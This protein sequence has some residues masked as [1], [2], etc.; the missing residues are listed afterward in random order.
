MSDIDGGGWQLVRHVPAGTVWH[1]ATD[2]LT[3]TDS[4]GTPCGPTCRHEW[5]VRF[6]NI[7]FNQFL[8]I[9]GDRKKWLIANKDQ[10]IGS[11]YSNQPRLVNKSSKN[12][13]SYYSKWYRRKGHVED[14]WVSLGDYEQSVGTGEVLYGEGHYMGKHATDVLDSHNGANVYIRL[15]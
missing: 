9:T 12:S 15:R 14:P 11:Y 10:L 4:Y 13:S 1:K 2:Q 6:L 3:G 5:S 7:R 8:I